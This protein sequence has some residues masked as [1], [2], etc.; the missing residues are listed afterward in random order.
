MIAALPCCLSRE[1]VRAS[2]SG[3]GWHQTSDSQRYVCSLRAQLRA[4]T[5][6]GDR[7]AELILGARI[8]RALS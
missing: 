3:A 8:R 1:A 7:A 4:A 6:L 5:A 2:T